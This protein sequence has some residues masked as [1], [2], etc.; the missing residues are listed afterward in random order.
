VL[1]NHKLGNNFSLSFCVA[2]LSIF[3]H[4]KNKCIISNTNR[5]YDTHSNTLCSIN[6]PDF[7]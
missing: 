7:N 6:E 4:H 2:I 3:K 1:T 5:F